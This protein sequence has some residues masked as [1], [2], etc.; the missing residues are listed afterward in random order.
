MY[1][2]AVFCSHQVRLIF[3]QDRLLAELEDMRTVFDETV[4]RLIHEKTQM[5]IVMHMASLKLVT[6][7][8]TV[9]CV[10]ALML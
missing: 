8:H 10:A 2:C 6:D 4:L 7:T 3:Q 9:S 5:D 1:I